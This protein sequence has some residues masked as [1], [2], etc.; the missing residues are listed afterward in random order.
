MRRF[1][2]GRGATTWKVVET[3]ISTDVGQQVS[4]RTIQRSIDRTR[5]KDGQNSS[6]E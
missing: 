5:D 1:P 3:L 4:A 6:K 2:S